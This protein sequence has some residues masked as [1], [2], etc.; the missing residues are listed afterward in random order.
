MLTH[1][2]YIYAKASTDSKS[3]LDRQKLNG[4]KIGHLTW[5]LHKLKQLQTTATPTNITTSLNV[6][7]SS[8]LDETNSSSV[9]LTETDQLEFR[10]YSG[11][12]GQKCAYGTILARSVTLKVI[13]NQAH[14]THTCIYPIKSAAPG[15]S[16]SSS[17]GEPKKMSHYDFITFRLND[18]KAAQL[19]KGMFFNPDPYVKISI[20]PNSFVFAAN[21][22]VDDAAASSSAS[23][24][25]S[26]LSA[27]SI[28]NFPHGASVTPN[29]FLF[30]S[31]SSIPFGYVRDY[32]TKVVANTCFPNWKNEVLT[33]SEEILKIF[34]VV[35]FPII[36]WKIRKI[37]LKNFCFVWESI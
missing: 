12:G 33:Q 2:I 28:I 14:T 20:V 16:T 21:S 11:G 3:F 26:P 34:S 23:A 27:S 31:R 35:F 17:C 4:S 5:S 32:K 8:P 13:L 36:S 30:Q 9:V 15:P 6:A 1:F 24:T 19:R 29:S 7:L 18:I 37:F 22:C 10:Y 25:S